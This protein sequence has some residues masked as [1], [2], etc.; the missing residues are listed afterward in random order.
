MFIYLFLVEESLFSGK[1]C[2]ENIIFKH[3]K[4]NIAFHKDACIKRKP[5]S[6][7]GVEIYPFSAG[8]SYVNDKNPVKYYPMYSDSSLGPVIL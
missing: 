7:N 4:K 8:A 1:P 6:W 5:I 3:L 2:F